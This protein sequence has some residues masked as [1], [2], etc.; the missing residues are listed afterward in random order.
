LIFLPLLG[1]ITILFGYILNPFF[2]AIFWAVLL[3]A[4][5]TPLNGRLHQKFK[6]P[7]CVP[8]SRWGVVLVS[9]ILPV[10]IIQLAEYL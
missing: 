2:F 3:A 1:I 10:G 6:T 4:V 9:L 5:F 7:I 8:V